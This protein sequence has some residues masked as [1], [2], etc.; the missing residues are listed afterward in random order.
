MSSD[1]SRLLFA[2]VRHTA[3]DPKIGADD[4]GGAAEFLTTLLEGEDNGPDPQADSII[5]RAIA[6][7]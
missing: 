3:A 5:A 6:A 1:I 2:L 7:L 4:F